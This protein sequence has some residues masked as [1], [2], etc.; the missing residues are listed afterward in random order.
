MTSKRRPPGYWNKETVLAEAKRYKNKKEWVKHSHHTY[1]M[2]GRNKWL[3][4][5]CLHMRN[6]KKPQRYWTIEKLL[7]DAKKYKTSSEWKRV[8][9]SAY[10]TACHSSVLE[11]CTQHME[12]MYKSKGYWTKNK[13]RESAKKH[14]TI[15]EWS[16]MDGAAYDAAKRNNWIGNSTEHM[17]KVFSHGE[18]TIYIFLLSHDLNFEYQKRFSDL[19]DKSYLPYDFYLPDFNLVIEYQGRQHFDA[20]H[21][22]RYKKDIDAIQRRDSMKRKY[23][24]DKRIAYLEIDA[25]VVDEIEGSII[26]KL[27]SIDD[28]LKLMKRKLTQNEN[29]VI[30]SLG[31]W[32]KFSV[33]TEARKYTNSTDW[34][35][36][37]NSSYYI[38]IKN[39]WFKEAT[40]HFKPK[41]RRNRYWSK[42]QVA[43]SASKYKTKTEWRL[44][45]PCASVVAYQKKWHAEVTKHMTEHSRGGCRK[46]RNYWTEERILTDAYSF[47]TVKDWRLT[48]G[49]SY[50]HAQ[51]KGLLEKATAHMSKTRKHAGYWTKERVFEDAR[52]YCSK[53]EWRLSNSGGY[54]GA[55]K[56]GWLDEALTQCK[57]PLS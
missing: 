42:D 53:K 26:N 38:S 50:R 37:G 41:R 22:S 18:L 36:C 39:G 20:S 9:A 27:K 48:E 6:V 11:E 24:K 14:L 55:C 35:S 52:N 10:A 30:S 44:A 3:E 2:A 1:K 56:K 12:K 25:E 57:Q 28:K 16:L 7:T 13:C 46:P 15:R 23:A 34:S 21:S 47:Q 51:T 45:D 33:I 8:S 17:I 19:K 43:L 29:K 54:K 49:S 32:D 4:E 31:R 40:T 5:A